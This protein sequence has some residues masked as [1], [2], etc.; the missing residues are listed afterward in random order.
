MEGGVVVEADGVVEGGDGG[1]M[2][3]WWKVMVW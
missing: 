3:V 1:V 2:V